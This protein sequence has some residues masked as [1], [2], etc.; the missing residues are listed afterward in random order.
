[1]ILHYSHSAQQNA[2]SIPDLYC[3]NLM[4]EQQHIIQV[5]A[6]QSVAHEFSLLVPDKQTLSYNELVSRVNELLVNNFDRL[7]SILYRLDVNEKLIKDSLESAV[8]QDAAHVI[9]RLIIERQIQKIKSRSEFKK[10]NDD[11]D[12]DE[13]W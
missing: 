11:I 12:A 2:S 4:E 7:I 8:G 1:M 13:K 9:S 3:L 10:S 6:L 5:E